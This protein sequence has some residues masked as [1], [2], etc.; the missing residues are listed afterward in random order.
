MVR[1]GG[2]SF[3]FYRDQANFP[4]RDKGAETLAL[5]APR[6][7]TQKVSRTGLSSLLETEAELL[8]PQFSFGRESY[9]QRFLASVPHELPPE[10][11]QNYFAAQSIWDDTMAWRAVEF[12]ENHP[13]QVL[14]IVVGEFHVAYW[15]GLPDRILSRG[16][17]NR[18]RRGLVW[19]LSQLNSAEEDWSGMQLQILPHPIW[20]QRADLI[21]VDEEKN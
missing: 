16:G 7:L 2:L 3:G 10:R 1:W 4:L 6:S 18:Q 11:Q 19:T 13:D 21:L 5:N 14:V 20:G 12:A 9:R 8:P 17:G 15:G